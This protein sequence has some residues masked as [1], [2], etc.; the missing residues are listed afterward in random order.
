MPFWMPV[1][2]GSPPGPPWPAGAAPWQLQLRL[3][4][5]LGSAL[6]GAATEIAIPTAIAVQ[7]KTF[8]IT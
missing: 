2:T 6:A 8:L 5:T 7:D 1:P 4:N 3:P